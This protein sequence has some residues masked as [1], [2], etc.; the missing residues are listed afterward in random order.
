MLLFQF[1]TDLCFFKI[2]V[3]AKRN[4]LKERVM[5]Y[6]LGKIL[7]SHKELVSCFEDL[8]I[9]KIKNVL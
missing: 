4:T 9:H 1:S 2:K 3:L 8:K 5:I 6:C 7:K